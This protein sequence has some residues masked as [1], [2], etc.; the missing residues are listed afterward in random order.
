MAFNM[1]DYVDVAS[2]ITEFYKTFPD[3]RL[4]TRSVE[5]IE[6]GALAIAEAYRTAE[7]PHPGVGTAWEPIPGK[8]SF[9]KDSEVQNA[10]TAAWGRAIIAVGIPSKKTVGRRGQSAPARLLRRRRRGRRVAF[11]AQRRP[12][13]QPPKRWSP[14]KPRTSMTLSYRLT[15]MFSGVTSSKDVPA[16]VSAVVAALNWYQQHPESISELEKGRKTGS[17]A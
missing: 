7:D 6:G 2:R 3:G 15:R 4:C 10:E 12:T 17:G 13:H 5:I 16:K 8:T 9:T 11:H 14:R 1:D